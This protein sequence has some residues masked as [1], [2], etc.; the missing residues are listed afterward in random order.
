MQ[1]SVYHTLNLFNFDGIGRFFVGECWIPLRD[2]ENVR[3]NLQTAS[4]SEFS[5]YTKVIKKSL[6]Q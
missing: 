1:K 3:E 2:I 5:S 4:V 6:P